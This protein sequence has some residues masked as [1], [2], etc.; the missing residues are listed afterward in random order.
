M[1][2]SGDLSHFTKNWRNWI[3]PLTLH[4]RHPFAYK[5]CR[6]YSPIYKQLKAAY[7]DFPANATNPGMNNIDYILLQSGEEVAKEVSLTRDTNVA[8]AKHLL[9]DIGTSTFDSSVW[10]FAC[11]YSQRRIDFD[12]VYGWELTPLQPTSYWEK[13]PPHWR[14]YWHFY[15]TPVKGHKGSSESPLTFLKEI[16][17]PRD[18]IG[19]KLDIDSPHTEIPLFE[20]LLEDNSESAALVDEFFFELHYRCEVMMPCGWGTKIPK[21]IGSISL[22]RF[23]ALASFSSL[24]KKGIRAHF[25]P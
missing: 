13:V 5:R 15:N 6:H 4:S 24:R 16:A 12:A 22:D 7:R 9:L 8:Q 14:P 11:A 3:E 21:K 19:L 18:F 10:W 17:S 25:W 1:S 20:Q 23:T 2:P